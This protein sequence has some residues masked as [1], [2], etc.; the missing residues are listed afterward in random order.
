MVWRK[1]LKQKTVTNSE[2]LLLLTANLCVCRLTEN[3]VLKYRL[4]QTEIF[5]PWLYE[6][7]IF[8]TNTIL[9]TITDNT[10]RCYLD[11]LLAIYFAGREDP[12]YRRSIAK[13]TPYNAR[14]PGIIGVEALLQAGFS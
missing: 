7:L 11:Y 10:S 6:G 1:L 8:T 4:N 3:K 12:L 9:G 5:H 13:I 14:T 2:M